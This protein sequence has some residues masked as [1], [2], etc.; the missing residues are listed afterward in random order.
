MMRPVIQFVALALAAVVLA[1][2]QPSIKD[3]DRQ[4]PFKTLHPW[5]HNW[6]EVQKLPSGVEYVIIH[7]GDGQGAFPSPADKVEVQY[8]G[9]LARTGEQFDSSWGKDSVTFRLKDVILGW[10][11]G[12]QKL[13]PGD[14]AMFWIPWRMAYGEEG[15]RQVPPKADL[16]FR[17]ELRRVIPA[18]S[19]DTDA[20]ARVTPWPTGSNDIV[21]RNSGLEYIVI[22]SGD[23]NGVS[24]VERDFVNL[25]VEGRIDGEKTDDGQPYVVQSTYADQETVRY[26]VGDLTPGWVELM[27]IMRPGDHWMVMMPPHLMY[28]TDGDG[29]IPPNATIIYEVRLESVIYIDPPPEPPPQ[30]TKPKARPKPKP[31]PN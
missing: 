18:V 30:A 24:P 10:Q 12:M 6:K 31:K 14:E 16:M 19:A 15:E 1:A 4:D 13:Q 21:R 23:T 17:V 25:H 20:W 27:K 7:K 2:C 22:E 3:I 5:K 11:Y 9:R 29:R 26:P 8:D 28:G